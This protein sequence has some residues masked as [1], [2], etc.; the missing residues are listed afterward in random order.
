M[1]I[2]VQDP[3]QRFEA[4]KEAATLNCD[5]SEMNSL[6]IHIATAMSKAGLGRARDNALGVRKMDETGT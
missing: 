6:V 5:G 4:A 2:S 3:D 1:T